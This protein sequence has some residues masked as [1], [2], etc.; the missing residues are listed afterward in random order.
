MI[1]S[2]RCVS[3]HKH[4]QAYHTNH[5][6]NQ[7]QRT[8]PNMTLNYISRAAPSTSFPCWLKMP[9][10]VNS[11]LVCSFVKHNSTGLCVWELWEKHL[12]SPWYS[13]RYPVKSQIK[14]TVKKQEINY[15][16][17][18]YWQRKHGYNICSSVDFLNAEAEL[19]LIV[20]SIHEHTR[21]SITLK[22]LTDQMN[23]PDHG[24]NV[25]F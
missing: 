7:M 11:G 1:P 3:T 9:T 18:G 8:L 4:L 17:P 21:I 13:L 20:N 25:M 24:Y 5:T 23:A 10:A 15:C 14:Y 22:P 16:L 2:F 19:W 6:L 12:Y